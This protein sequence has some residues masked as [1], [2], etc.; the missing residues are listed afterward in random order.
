MDVSHY[1]ECLLVLVKEIG[2]LQKKRILSEPHRACHLDNVRHAISLEKQIQKLKQCMMRGEM[3]SSDVHLTM[4]QI[5][6]RFFNIVLSLFSFYV[7]HIIKNSI[8]QL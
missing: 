7:E 8:T 2:S 3:S 5:Q 4:V 6:Y 1:V